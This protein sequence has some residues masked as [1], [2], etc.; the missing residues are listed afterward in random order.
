MKKFLL[1]LLGVI[2]IAIV[3]FFGMLG[4]IPGLSWALGAERPKD[5]GIKYTE[6]DRTSARAK[7]QIEYAVLPSDTPAAQSFVFSGSR[8]V[9]TSWNSAEMTALMNN[10]PWKYWPIENVQLRINDDGTTELS[11]VVVKSK[12]SGYAA[13]IGVPADVADNII[14]YLPPK[15]AFYVKSKTSLANNQVDQFDIQSVSLGK[16]PIP[17]N[18]LLS[19]ASTQLIN[20]ALAADSFTSQLSQYSGKKQAIVNFINDKLRTLLPGFYAKTAAFSGGKL[21]FDGTLSETEATAR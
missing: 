4:Y 5:L 16:M 7:S 9:T 15:S 12:L 10:R 1:I 2:V 19:Q 14:K 20:S 17:T 8:P 18:V 6:A 13:A 3:L 11:G 21:N